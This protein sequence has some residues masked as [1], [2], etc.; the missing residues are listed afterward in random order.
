MTEENTFFKKKK[1]DESLIDNPGEMFKDSPD[2]PKRRLT[3]R[4]SQRTLAGIAISVRPRTIKEI[5]VITG[6]T[7]PNNALRMLQSIGAQK[8]TR[9]GREILYVAPH[10]VDKPLDPV[11]MAYDDWLLGKADW[12]EALGPSEED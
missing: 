2:L 1:F 7:R 10:L 5:M 6:I 12:P 8:T 4:S 9:V 3:V 11:A